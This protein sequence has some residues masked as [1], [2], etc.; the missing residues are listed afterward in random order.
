MFPKADI[1]V[2][3]LS[4]L[5]SASPEQH[6]RV[7]QALDGLRQEG[8][9]ILGSGGLVHNLRELMPE[10]APPDSWA[11]SF[12]TWLS[13]RLESRALAELFDYASQ[14]ENADLAHPTDEHLLPLFVSMGAGWSVMTYVI[15][16]LHTAGNFQ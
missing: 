5:R 15:V 4:L 9:I 3:Q 12:D 16:N 10:G 1:P 14:A 13:D 11:Q 7:G 8:V 2:V 6:F